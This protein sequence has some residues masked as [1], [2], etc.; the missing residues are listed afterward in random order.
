MVVVVGGHTR[1]IG[2][3]S[4][5]CGII[6]ALP[7][8]NWTAIKISRHL[9]SIS[10]R[11][12]SRED[13]TFPSTDSGRFLASGAVRSFWVRAPVG[14]LSKAIAAIRLLLAD[15]E[16]A[17]VES[18]SILH[19]LK[20]DFC[21]MVLDGTVADFKPTSLRF[22]R[23]A[24]VLVVT[25]PAPLGWPGVPPSLLQN[26]PRFAAPAPLYRNAHLLETIRDI[27]APAVG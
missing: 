4:V 15:S 26:K 9:H 1:N 23:R 27:V 7:D 13:G 22:L 5:I 16:N 6:R 10:S 20:P 11:D 18:N 2:K 3:T 25:S 19:F 21:A 12:I 8:F 24:N 17:I 14:E